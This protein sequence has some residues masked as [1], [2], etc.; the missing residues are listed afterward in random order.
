MKLLKQFKLFGIDLTPR[1]KYRNLITILYEEYNKLHTAYLKR[2]E[3]VSTLKEENAK[4]RKQI[5]FTGVYRGADG[6]IHS[7]K[8]IS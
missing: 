4:L 3:E 5:A 1:R 7:N 2:G 6:R 8:K